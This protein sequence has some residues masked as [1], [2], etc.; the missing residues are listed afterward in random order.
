MGN[1][2]TKGYDFVKEGS[3]TTQHEQGRNSDQD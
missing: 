2:N 3:Q 1:E